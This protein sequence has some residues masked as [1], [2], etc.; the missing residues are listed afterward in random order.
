MVNAVIPAE[1]GI[2]CF[3]FQ[4]RNSVDALSQE[5]RALWIPAFAGMTESGDH[6][7]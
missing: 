1:A 6:C 3:R 2:Q 5:V 7:A 4:Q